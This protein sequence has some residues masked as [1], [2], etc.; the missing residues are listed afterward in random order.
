MDT[1]KHSVNSKKIRRLL[2]RIGDLSKYVS[3]K[4]PF[5]VICGH[6]SSFIIFNVNEF[7]QR[8]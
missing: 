4:L 7:A 5:F 2:R 3:N 8:L 6:S 1:K